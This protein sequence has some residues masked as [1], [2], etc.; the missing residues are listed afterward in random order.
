M[1]PPA[2]APPG[3]APVACPPPGSIE[4]TQC[5]TCGYLHVPA[6]QYRCVSCGGRSLTPREVALRGAVETFTVLRNAAN[7]AVGV[8]LVRL[9]AGPL[10]TVSLDV[11]GAAPRIGE[12]VEGHV[13]REALPEAGRTAMR[14]RFAPLS[15]L[16][17]AAQ[18]IASSRP[19][20]PR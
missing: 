15:S 5:E 13:E 16:S 7:A 3:A 8:A 1:S 20:A 10:V 18:P 19:E 2:A 17:A 4:A 9:D 6:R 12:R 14:L 11:S